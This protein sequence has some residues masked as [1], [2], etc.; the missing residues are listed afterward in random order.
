MLAELR[1]CLIESA[2]LLVFSP[3]MG[4]WV[5]VKYSSYRQGGWHA[6][7]ISEPAYI[8]GVVVG[9]MMMLVAWCVHGCFGCKC[10]AAR[11]H[12]G[13]A[14]DSACR[15]RLGGGDRRGWWPMLQSHIACFR[16]IEQDGDNQGLCLISISIPPFSL[17]NCPPGTRLCSPFSI[18][19]PIYSVFVDLPVP[20]VRTYILSIVFLSIGL[21]DSHSLLILRISP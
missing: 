8:G 11:T 13:G 7:E 6:V 9:G 14:F 16:A 5:E 21:Y 3:T 10:A 19:P 18:L 20:L 17:H 12:A 4:V 2:H 15:T 1:S